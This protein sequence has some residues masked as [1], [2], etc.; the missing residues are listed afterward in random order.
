[1]NW[2]LCE[3]ELL[4]CGFK[5]TITK[6]EVFVIPPSNISK[7][8]VERVFNEICSKYSDEKVNFT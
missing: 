7:N 3:K 1:M 4:N 6:D 2:A 8:E 5:V